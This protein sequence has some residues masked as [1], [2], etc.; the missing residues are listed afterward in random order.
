MH[1]TCLSTAIARDRFNMAEEVPLPGPSTHPLRANLRA[2]QFEFN[3]RSSG[4]VNYRHPRSLCGV[5]CVTYPMLNRPFARHSSVRA[6]VG[7]R[8]VGFDC[9]AIKF[10]KNSKIGKLRLF[11]TIIVDMH[12]Q[13]LGFRNECIPHRSSCHADVGS[14]AEFPS[15]S[16]YRRCRGLWR[17]IQYSRIY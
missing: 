5:G 2:F 8:V 17:R 14:P 11:L 13:G 9:K 7:L 12:A 3:V 1:R 4:T 10:P 15:R 6:I 16:P